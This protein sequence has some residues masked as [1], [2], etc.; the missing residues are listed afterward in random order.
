MGELEH[1]TTLGLTGTKVTAVVVQAH[2]SRP[3]PCG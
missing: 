2:L 1:L 3:V